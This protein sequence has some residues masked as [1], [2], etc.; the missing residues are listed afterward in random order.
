MALHNPVADESLPTVMEG[1]CA[2]I[3][4]TKYKTPERRNVGTS[5]PRK[6]AFTPPSMSMATSLI[7]GM[8]NGDDALESIS[9]LY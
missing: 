9:I 3:R 8:L 7:S 2:P 6:T 5:D 1:K 4:P